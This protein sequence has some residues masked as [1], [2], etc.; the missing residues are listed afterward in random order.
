[1]TYINGTRCTQIMYAFYNGFV[2]TIVEER[3]PHR[4]VYNALKK[5]HN[6]ASAK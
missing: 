6:V 3:R 4:N 2:I 5:T 1:M